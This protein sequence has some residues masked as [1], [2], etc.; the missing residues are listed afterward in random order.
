MAADRTYL[1]TEQYRDAT[2]L[3]ARFAAVK[4][5]GPIG[6]PR[7]L[8]VIVAVLFVVA[9]CQVQRAP[10]PVGVALLRLGA[11]VRLTDR[12]ALSPVAWAP[13]GQ[14]LAYADGQGLWISTLAGRERKVTPVGVATQ[15]EWSKAA[16]LLA[17]IDRGVVMVVRTDGAG[18]RR[19]P[20][21]S[22]GAPF[23][24]HLAWA[25]GGAD[26]AVAARTT[27]GTVRSVVWLLSADG[28]MRRQI[29]PAQGPGGA[30]PAGLAVAA[31]QW[32]PDGLFLFIGLSPEG[33]AGMTRLWRWRIRYPDRRVLP[34]PFSELLLPR[35]SPDGQ[36]IAFAASPA[37]GAEPLVW[38]TRVDG[39]GSP[40]R[41]S[42]HSGRFT[43]L[44]WAPTSDKVAFAR[45]LDESHG[46]IWLADV[47]GGG[48]VRAAEFTAEFPDPNLPLVVRWSGDGRHLAFGSN[49]GSYT[50][51]VW[52]IVLERK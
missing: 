22:E 15:V 43:S 13:D 6:F 31:L 9:G 23:V 16:G 7:A 21:P 27:R 4:P 29:L 11:P 18:R 46:E 48:R 37:V 14:S 26:L 51:P 20:L 44:A 40:R 41:L 1:R 19:L 5:E 50:G 3:R 12:A 38:A 45:V 30:V 8:A 17:Y 28:R 2:N 33:A 25:P 39:R 36:W 35:L 32:Y 49:S 10:A 42:P 52:I 24:T 47:D 34:M